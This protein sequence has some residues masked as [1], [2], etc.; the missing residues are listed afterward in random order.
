MGLEQISPD[1]AIY[2][3]WGWLQLNA[4]IL[5]T[6]L[7]GSIIVGGAWLVTRSLKTDF[8]LSRWQHFLEI[9][10]EAMLGQIREVVPS[11]PERYL[12]F[13]GTL[14]VFIAVSNLLSIVPYFH[15]PTASLSTDAA[16]ALC[17]L[18]AVPLYGIREQGL[19]GYL[20]LYIQPS[21][22]MLP[23]NVI[24]ELSRTL[25]LAVRLF[26]NMM[27]GAKIAAI[28]LLVAPLLFPVLTQLLGLLTG[29]IQAYIFAML[30]LVYIASATQAHQATTTRV[31]TREPQDDEPQPQQGVLHD[32]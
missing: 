31:A 27:S 6:W 21:P 18:V 32:G 17:V 3:Q 28:L 4:T 10:I 29:L 24:G 11:N 5:F 26:G 7:V 2:W 22:M 12:P 25:A 9:V 14:F 19:V 30:A 16:L 8:P 15:A 23:F 1:E 20:K 13:I